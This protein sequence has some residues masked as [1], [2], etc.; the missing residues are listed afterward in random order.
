MILRLLPEASA[1]EAGSESN[2]N[3]AGQSNSGRSRRKRWQKRCVGSMSDSAQISNSD[4]DIAD[5]TSVHK[6][7]LMISQMKELYELLA[8]RGEEKNLPEET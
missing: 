8:N 7:T 2:S 3:L 6:E 5:L 4:E 1:R